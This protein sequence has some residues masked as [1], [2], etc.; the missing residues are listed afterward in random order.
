MKAQL[1]TEIRQ[2]RDAFDK[3]KRMEYDEII[4]NNLMGEEVFINARVVMTYVSMG[5]EV[6][7]LRL[8]ERCFAD[9]KKVCVP[10]TVRG[11]QHMDISYIDSLD[12][13]E[14]G[15][16]EILQP[17]V[18]KKCDVADVDLIIVPA[19]AFDKNGH[20]IGYGGGYYDRF[21]AD[22]NGS[23]IGLCYDFCMADTAFPEEHDVA[24][25]VVITERLVK[26]FD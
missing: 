1:R 24:V 7:T 25:D 3:S 23:T 20:R 6:D 11:Q 21:L 2:R 16:Y 15:A 13:L 9:G 22:Y 12:D 8:I 26:G 18:Y 17:T 4:Y 19:V 10:V 14:A 5:S